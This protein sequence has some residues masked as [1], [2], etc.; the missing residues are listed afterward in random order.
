MLYE[1]K[2]STNVRLDYFYSSMLDIKILP[3]L[4]IIKFS[5]ITHQEKG[6]KMP[7]LVVSPEELNLVNFF[8][9]FFPQEIIS[10]YLYKSKRPFPERA[11][12]A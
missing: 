7:V 12:L 3:V 5:L 9:Y 6:R 2:S 11:E 10:V 1:S 8:F 4:M